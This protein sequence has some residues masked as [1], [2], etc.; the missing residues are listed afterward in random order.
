MR[1]V[2][3]SVVALPV[4]GLLAVGLCPGAALAATAD[5]ST[6]TSP[7]GSTGTVSNPFCSPALF[8]AA[9]QRAAQALVSRVTQLE[10][11]SA[12]VEA[13]SS[14]LSPSDQSTLAHDITAV[15]LPGIEALQPEVQ[16]AT[17]CP[18]VRQDAHAMVYD[19][20]VY[21]VMTPQT[22][23]TIVADRE[24]FAAGRLSALEPTVQSAIAW[25][26]AHGRN[27]TD[28]ESAFGD[29]QARV[30]SATSALAGVA[31]T[32]LAQTPTGYPGNAAVFLS[33]RTDETNA[34]N[35]LRSAFDDLAAIAKDIGVR[36][37]GTAGS[38]T[39][40]AS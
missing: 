27:V 7:T 13:P 14:H 25:A 28:A 39:T 29:M 3:R 35:D 30:S 10:A 40:T 20:R 37:A 38:T 5:T 11:L 34:R 17:T 24:S 36:G 4:L 8:R 16:Q 9:Q 18:Q 6:T 2:L 26:R 23:E 32:V 15:E 12:L 31:A 1:P 21:L 19:Y 22:H 33:A